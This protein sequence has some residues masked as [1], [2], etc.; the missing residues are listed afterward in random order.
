[1]AIY[2]VVQTVT[3]NFPEAKR[4][5]ILINDEPAETLAGHISLAHA[6][7]PMPSLVAAGVPALPTAPAVAPAATVTSR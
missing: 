3:A 7:A 1:M 2:S 4:V 6:L 5:R